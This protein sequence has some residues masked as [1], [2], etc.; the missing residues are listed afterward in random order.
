VEL[1]PR[2]YKDFKDEVIRRQREKLINSCP[3][4]HEDTVREFYAN[5]YP[6]SFDETTRTS[7][8]RGMQ[9]NYDA[10]SLRRHLHINLDLIEEM[11]KEIKR[12]MK[13]VSLTVT[14]KSTIHS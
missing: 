5:A 10:A 14:A 1:L 4:F 3:Y 13:D 8:V 11:R 7:W 6:I 2:D 12:R 9:V